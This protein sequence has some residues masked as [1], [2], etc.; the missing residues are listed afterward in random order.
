M[1]NNL[2]PLL[3]VLFL[4]FIVYALAKPICL[5]FMTQDDFLRRR[6]VWFSLTIVAF[7]S[8]SFWLYAIFAL[9]LMYWA[10]R[11]DS[12]PI[13]LYA[14]L[15]HVIPPVSKELPAVLINQLFALNNYRILAIAILLPTA[16]KL[17]QN[18]DK[19]SYGNHK[20]ADG[21]ILAYGILQLILLMPYE[22]ITN[23][24]RRGVLYILD[25]VVL[26]YVVSRICTNREKLIEVMASFCLAC[27]IFV[28][29]AV[30]E[31][32]RSWLLYTQVAYVWG[33]PMPS[34][35]L[36][37]AETLRAQASTGHSL[38]LGLLLAVA[39]GFWLFLSSQLKS[40]PKALIGSI[41]I[42]IGLVAGFSRASWVAGALIFFAYQ[43]LN[44]AGLAR[45]FKTLLIATPIAGLVLVSPLGERVIKFLPFI[46]TV[47]SFN[48]DYR[49]QL[50]AASWERIKEYPFFGDPFFMS[51]LEFL[52][53]GQGI[54]DLVNVYAAIAMFSGLVG[55]LL[56]LGPFLI[57]ILPTLKFAKFSSEPML[58]SNLLG[59]SLLATAAGVAILMATASFS[60]A[61]PPV[62][63]LLTGLLAGYV[64]LS[65][66]ES[67]GIKVAGTPSHARAT[68]Q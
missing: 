44:P 10:G 42:W 24:L 45:F 59:A 64:Q 41:G 35:Y 62:Y 29:I 61:L 47:D 25:A 14:L 56:F 12:N 27:A 15:L 54:I 5:K 51:H 23:T 40:K 31:S 34:A 36:F 11:K 21:F 7:L 38:A 53:Q 8:P 30:F 50:A 19:T 55:L 60:G 32:L 28:P 58:A 63:Y 4:A 3:V 33:I 18:Q 1:I 22:E 66:L 68:D 37:R 26:F 57:A 65:I 46:G 20:S 16:W 52:K 48:V 6:N 49:Q 39:F 2:K 9:G 17:I 43:F 13:A 67:V